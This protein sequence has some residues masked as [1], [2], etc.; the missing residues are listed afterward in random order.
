M[1]SQL[2][3]IV[4]LWVEDGNTTPLSF[5]SYKA[6]RFTRSVLAAEVISLSDVFK[7]VPTLCKELEYLLKRHIPLGAPH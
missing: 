7:D 2:G 4:F 5:K 6:G 3:H 1:L